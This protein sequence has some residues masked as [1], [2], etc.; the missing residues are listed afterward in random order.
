MKNYD[1]TLIVPPMWS[2]TAPWTASGFL[3]EAL[4]KRGFRV[5]FL[6]YN[7]Q[8]FH[9]CQS[10]GFGNLWSDPSFIQNWEDCAFDYLSHIFDLDEIQGGVI[11]FCATQTGLRSAVTLAK[12]IRDHFP[13][14]KIIFGGHAVYF[15]DGATVVPVDVADAICKGEGEEVV[16]EMLNK[17]FRRWREIPGLYLPTDKGWVLNQ[18]RPPVTDLD[19]FPWPTYSEVDLS[20][21]TKPY[22]GLVG[23]RGCLGR[24]VFCSERQR[25]PGH[26]FRSVANQV[27]ELE[28]LSS[29]YP[30]E[31]FPYYDSLVNGNY[32]VL[33]E[34]AEEIIRRGLKVDYSGN[35]M[36]RESMADDLFPLLRKSGF[37]VAFIGIESGSAATLARM[38][39]RHN[40]R[41][42]AD[43][44][45]KCHNAGIRTE[46]NI[47]IGFP[48]ETETHFQETLD[49]V[50]DNR[51]YI[52]NIISL[53][54]FGLAH[55]D[56]CDKLEEYGIVID[57]KFANGNEWHTR[58][59][60]NDIGVRR[61]RMETFLKL[62]ETL[63]LRGEYLFSDEHYFGENPPPAP[64][65]FL[66]AYQKADESLAPEDRLKHAASVDR[67]RLALRLRHRTPVETAVKMVASIRGRGLL[68]SVRRI[69]EK[70]RREAMTRR[71][72]P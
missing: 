69:R 9:A 25:F 67:L 47:I 12:R 66:E 68:K 40:P 60:P 57:R 58:E 43:F 71:Q 55:S 18:E 16:C 63:G 48:T 23:S 29:T 64:E 33:R 46:I 6:D 31:H 4:R 26:R 49:F 13:R 36:V 50:R 30:I 37:S 42:A 59:H 14:R 3:C 35:M 45:K 70:I 41:M 44:L 17:D 8:L 5:Q 39:K 20:R 28:Y 21:Y 34:K 24:C 38:R 7:I 19:Q 54:T 52:D 1:I 65:S 27:D 62:E 10:I 2:T 56:L 32:Q 11:G 72:S 15:P 51:Q 22:L 61:A 53:N